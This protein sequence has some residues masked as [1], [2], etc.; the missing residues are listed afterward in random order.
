MSLEY[1]TSNKT[2]G[3]GEGWCWPWRKTSD[4]I[5]AI[6]ASGVEWS[7]LA[8]EQQKQR[9]LRHNGL[10]EQYGIIAKVKC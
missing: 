6:K 3:E 8:L 1:N 10:C 5:R 9:G 2:G 4:L 7:Q